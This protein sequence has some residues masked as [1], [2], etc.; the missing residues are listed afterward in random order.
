MIVS[1]EVTAGITGFTLFCR[2]GSTWVA[3]FGVS[4]LGRCG[5]IKSTHMCLTWIINAIPRYASR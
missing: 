4:P 2:G 5:L 1:P 3:H